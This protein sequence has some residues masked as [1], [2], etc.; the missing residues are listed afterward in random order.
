MVF[1]PMLGFTGVAL[2]LLMLSGQLNPPFRYRNQLSQYL[3]L[4]IGIGLAIYGLVLVLNG[5]RGRRSLLEI[6]GQSVRVQEARRRVDLRLD[7][8]LSFQT[9]TIHRRCRL[10]VVPM[11]GREYFPIL[12]PDG[13]DWAAVAQ[14]FEQR[15]SE[16][17]AFASN[18]QV[19]N[20]PISR[21]R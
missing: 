9:K 11:D 20:E 6:S 13:S 10:V 4:A 17:T 8:V 12:Q 3:V 7:K 15:L 19:S 21:L 2:S 1:V 14:R 5:W 16:H 18:P